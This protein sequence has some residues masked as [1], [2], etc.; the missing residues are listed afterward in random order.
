MVYNAVGLNKNQYFDRNP[1]AGN[2]HVFPIYISSSNTR[3]YNKF[4]CWI[5]I[6]LS[7]IQSG[8]GHVI[9]TLTP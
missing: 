9:F 4:Q 5:F 3:M 1:S 6:L 2:F 7:P 8:G